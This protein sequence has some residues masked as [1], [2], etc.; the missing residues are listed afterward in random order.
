MVPK[1]VL[2]GLPWCECDEKG[3]P[4]RASRYAW[5]QF[6]DRLPTN[7]HGQPQRAERWRTFGRAYDELGKYVHV[8]EVTPQSFMDIEVRLNSLQVCLGQYLMDG[9]DRLKGVAMRDR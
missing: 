8:A 1:T 3:R 7:F 5:I 9:L 2:V 4:T 6:G